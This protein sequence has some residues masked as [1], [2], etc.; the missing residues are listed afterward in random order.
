MNRESTPFASLGL[1]HSSLFH[2]VTTNNKQQ[3]VYKE[4]E[5]EGS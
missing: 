1:D 4:I 5:E 2:P 3:K